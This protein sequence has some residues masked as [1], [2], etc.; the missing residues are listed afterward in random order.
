MRALVIRHLSVNRRVLL[1]FSLWAVIW[2]LGA[3]KGPLAALSGGFLLA[4]VFSAF[5]MLSH[6]AMDPNLER[7]LLS[8]PVGRGQLVRETY[9]SGL[10]AILLGQSLPLLV[11]MTGHALAP[12]SIPALDLSSLG[13]AALLFLALLSLITFM[14]PFRFA[15]GGPKGLMAFSIT[16]VV[17]LAAVLAW[18][19]LVG[20]IEAIGALGGWMLDEPRHG[21][22]VALG[23]LAFAGSSLAF[24][25]RAYE[26]RTL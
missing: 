21:L 17:I 11:L 18:K 25:I 22:F 10:L 1:W 24:S 12:N 5:V 3:L 16:L 6:E 26:Q 19:G 8:L 13:V 20:L 7:F 9:L 2:A 4:L 23:V 15:L 14:L